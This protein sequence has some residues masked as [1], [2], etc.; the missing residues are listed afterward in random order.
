MAG[1]D[2]RPFGLSAPWVRR[3]VGLAE[4]DGSEGANFDEKDFDLGALNKF[5]VE[6]EASLAVVLR[7]S[8]DLSEEPRTRS[9]LEL[10]R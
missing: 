8:G 3:P 1:R 5:R 6:A 7:R 2:V 4:P 9:H 10:G